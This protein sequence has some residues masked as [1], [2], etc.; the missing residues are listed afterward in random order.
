[1]AHAEEALFAH[2]HERLRCPA[3]EAEQA[4]G[5]LEVARNRRPAKQRSASHRKRQPASEHV[6][7]LLALLQDKASRDAL[8]EA[9]RIA[10]VGSRRASPGQG[11]LEDA[12]TFLDEL[13]RAAGHPGRGRSEA[14]CWADLVLEE[15]RGVLRLGYRS[16][17]TLAPRRAEALRRP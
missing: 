8:C 5:H 2:R 17:T 12:R 14:P 11:P 9:E 16:P 3:E 6:V 4:K 15:D 1:M 10:L 7:E 13:S